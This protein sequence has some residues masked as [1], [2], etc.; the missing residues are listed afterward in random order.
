MNRDTLRRTLVGGGAGAILFGGVATLQALRAGADFPRVLQPI[1]ML[2][3]IGLTVGALAG[4]LVGQA[5]A[6]RRGG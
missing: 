1:L 3:V 2:A 4:P 6:R 5:F